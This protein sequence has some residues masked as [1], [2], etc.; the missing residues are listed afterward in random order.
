MLGAA[1]A[2]EKASRSGGLPGGG[3]GRALESRQSRDVT[4]SRKGRDGGI[5]V[6]GTA[7]LQ[8]GGGRKK[9]SDLKAVDC[10][11]SADAGSVEGRA[12][13][14]TAVGERRVPIVVSCLLAWIV[15]AAGV[16]LLRPA[17]RR[18]RVMGA[19]LGWLGLTIA[20]MPLVLLAGAALR[21]GGLVEGLL[22]G[23]GAPALAI[24][25]A[26]LAPGWLGLAIACGAVA[27]AYATDVIAGSPLTTLS[28][29]AQMQI[30]NGHTADGAKTMDRALNHPTAQAIDLHLYG[31][32]LLADKKPEEADT[33]EQVKQLSD[34]PTTLGGGHIREGVVV[35]PARE[36]TDPKVGRAILKYIGDSYLFAKGVTDTDDV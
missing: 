19:A 27:C 6:V 35:R 9:Y 24:L 17:D 30:L 7:L 11:K 10:E 5:N 31:R 36:R 34:G 3:P 22:V 32:Q 33:L 13:R 12:A 1:G 2:A 23:L 14:M 26:A 4:R 16:A 25:T 18:G 28:L 29:L 21:P 8:R 15:V 20:W